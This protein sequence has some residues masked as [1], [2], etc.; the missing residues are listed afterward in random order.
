M[1]TSVPAP[2]AGQTEAVLQVFQTA[3][4]PLTL[5]QALKLYEGPKLS[6]Q[7]FSRIVEDRLLMEGQLFKCSPAR[8]QDRF[9]VHD[10]EEKVRETVEELLGQGPLPEGKLVTATNKALPKISSP[11][12][13]KGYVQSMAR[14]GFL[15]QWPGKGETKTLALRPFDPLAGLTFKKATLKD[16]SDALRRVEPLGVSV[17]RF[18]QVLRQYLRPQQT[19]FE[20][21]TCPPRPEGSG[22]QRGEHP[23][24]GEIEE[25]ILKGMRDLDTVV[26]HGATV[27]LR[28][29]RRNMPAE[30]GRHETFDTAVMRL[31]EQGRV[32]LH[33]HDQPSLLT[34]AERDELVR[35]EAGTYYTSIGLRV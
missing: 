31:A 11:A 20:A 17:D 32:V 2:S 27:L 22:E 26:E 35:D 8:K 7:Q 19:A 6:K 13:I 10:E 14:E 25:L 21:F 5:T 4:H 33:R 9:W 23:P 3:A 1:T 24:A 18:L 28:D 16:L 30:Y 15:H 12:A 29:L 34:D